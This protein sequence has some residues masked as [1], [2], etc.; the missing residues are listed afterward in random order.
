MGKRR[1][2]SSRWLQEHHN[3][4]YVLRARRE[5]YRSRAAFKLL[6]MT[7]HPFAGLHG[8]LLGPGMTVVDLGAA[9]GGWSQVAVG[10]VGATGRVVAMDL[11]PMPPLTGVNFIQGDFLGEEGLQ[12][13]NTVL[14]P[15]RQVDVVLSDMAPNMTGIEAI[16][17]TR[18]ELLAEAAHDFACT[19]LAQGGNLVVKLFQGPGFHDT[20]RRARQDFF[21]VKVV[22]PQASRNRS[23]EQYL[24][25]V[26]FRGQPRIQVTSS[27]DGKP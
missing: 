23:A 9:P 11:L 16:D 26:G 27:D 19:V 10:L 1:P 17:Q 8:R 7:E 18:G 6:E 4:P 14:S 21:R 20:V 15:E 3:D 2:S 24:V 22:K 13:L 25:G 5:G 12:H